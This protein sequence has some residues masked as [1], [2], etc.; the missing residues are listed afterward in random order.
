[1]K[2]SIQGIYLVFTYSTIFKV[3]SK[4]QSYQY[5]IYNM[6]QYA[7]ELTSLIKATKGLSNYY[8]IRLQI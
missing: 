6:V 7:F 8:N 5:Y 1:M 3:L 2:G 4:F